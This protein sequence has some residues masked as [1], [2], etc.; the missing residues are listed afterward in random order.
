M[1]LSDTAIRNAK[2]QTKQYKLFDGGGLFLIVRPTGGKLWRL[3]YRFGGKE[4]QLSI[5]TYPE[6]SL[7]DARERREDARRTLD[8]GADPSV[9]RKKV[10]AAAVL[11]AGSTFSVIAEE[12]LA[13]RKADG[14]VDHTIIKNKR[15]I[16]LIEADI[17][18]LPITE[19]EPFQLLQALKKIERQGLH[20]T[21]KRTRALVAK[22]YRYAIVTGRATK[23]P[24]TDLGEALIVHKPVHHA[25]LTKPDAVGELMR[26]IEDYRG[27]IFT[28]LAL[29]LAPH[30]FVRPGELRKAE[31]D[32]FDFDERVWRIPPEKMK[33]RI[34]HYEPLSR[35]VLEILEEA[36]RYR[37][38]SIYVFPA[39]LTP[40][41]PMS[42]NTLN[43]AL[44]R[45]GY[46]ADEM[47]SHGFRTTASTL[48][49]ESRKW[50]ADAI[51]RALAHQLPGTVRGIYHRGQH[52]EER[53][54]MAQW[55][56][57][58]LDRLREGGKVIQLKAAT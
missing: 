9:E 8:A 45:M 1:A 55:W 50:S 26:G 42:E 23:N 34:V 6:T 31:W 47:T 22:I 43:T 35:Q 15:F 12:Y 46:A 25:A 44:R 30:L 18:R 17:G 49:N 16:T 56:S 32:E 21:A 54:E 19:I 52:W 14:L 10:A 7:K 20:E 5:G 13:K 48:L 29:R 37:D 36:K 38:K 3:K 41:R 27:H 53:V 58:Y 33:M 40:Q 24:A 4:L 39:V 2:P 28:K 11:A 51:E 57:D